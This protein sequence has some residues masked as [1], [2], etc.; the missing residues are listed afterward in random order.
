MNPYTK[1]EQTPVQTELTLETSTEE[2]WYAYQ[3]FLRRQEEA[4][5]ESNKSDKRGETSFQM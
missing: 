1:D 5:E 3:A 4:N 2:L